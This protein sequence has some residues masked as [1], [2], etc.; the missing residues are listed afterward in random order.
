MNQLACEQKISSMTALVFF[1]M[2]RNRQFRITFPFVRPIVFTSLFTRLMLPSIFF[3]LG[4]SVL[5]KMS[6]SIIFVV[7]GQ[8]SD[9][10]VVLFD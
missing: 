6:G 8:R 2:F 7:S 4:T 9:F 5:E 3:K 10:K 1:E